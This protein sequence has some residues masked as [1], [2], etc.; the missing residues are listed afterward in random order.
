MPDFL[1]ALGEEPIVPG[2]VEASES[3]QVED[4][5]SP[6]FLKTLR[7]NHK[8]RYWLFLQWARANIR[9][10]AREQAVLSNDTTD[11]GAK[12]ESDRAEMQRALAWIHGLN[13]VEN[14]LQIHKEG[15]EGATLRPEQIPA[16]EALQKFLEN[17][18]TEGYMSLPTGFGKTVIFAELVEALDRPTLIVVPSKILVDQTVE[19]ME[20][21]APDVDVGRIYSAAKETGR[22]VTIIT[23]ASFLR[24]LADGTLNPADFDVLI[25]DEVHLSLSKARMEAISKFRGTLKIGYTATDTYSTRKDVSMLLANKIHKVTLRSAIEKKMLSSLRC[26]IVK[27]DVDLS[28]VGISADGDYDEVEMSKVLDIE[29]RNHSAVQLYQQAFSGEKAITFC[30]NIKHASNVAEA[31]NKDGVTAAVIHGGMSNEEQQELKDKFR[32][33]EITVLCNA[34]LLIVGFDDDEAS[35][36]LN[37]RPTRS[38]VMAGQRGGRVTRLDPNRPGKFAIVVDWVDKNQQR[39]QILYSHIAGGAYIVPEDTTQRGGGDRCGP[40]DIDVDIP[41]VEFIDDI[42]EVLR[43]SQGLAEDE[44]VNTPPEGWMTPA[45]LADELDINVNIIAN[46][47]RGL[48]KNVD[49]ANECNFEI[50]LFSDHRGL[51]V[52]HYS[53]ALTEELRRFF[54]YVKDIPVVPG[55][56]WVAFPTLTDRII[57]AGGRTDVDTV[58]RLIDVGYP[59]GEGFTETLCT[60]QCRYPGTIRP[61]IFVSPELVVCITNAILKEGPPGSAWLTF[62]QLAEKCGTTPRAAEAYAKVVRSGSGQIKIF[63]PAG[64]NTSEKVPHCSGSLAYRVYTYFKDLKPAPDGWLMAGEIEQDLR[65]SKSVFRD[66]ILPAM[67]TDNKLPDGDRATYMDRNKEPQEYYSPSFIARARARLATLEPPAEWM[68]VDDI[69]SANFPGVNMQGLVI[70]TA[71]KLNSADADTGDGNGQT[72][73]RWCIGVEDA[74]GLRNM[75][76]Y[77]SPAVTAITV[78]GLRKRILPEGWGTI[79]SLPGVA[80]GKRKSG[81]HSDNVCRW[82]IPQALADTGLC[83]AEHFGPRLVIEGA[84]CTEEQSCSPDLYARMKRIMEEEIEPPE[85]WKTNREIA[86]MLKRSV[87][88]VDMAVRTACELHEKPKHFRGRPPRGWRESLYFY[89]PPRLIQAVVEALNPRMAAEAR[90]DMLTWVNRDALKGELEVS[91]RIMRIL[92]ARVRSD[93]KK[94]G[95][96]ESTDGR[97]LSDGFVNEVR[98]QC[99]RFVA[100]SADWLPADEL[101]EEIGGGVNDRRV[102]AAARTIIGEADEATAGTLVMKTYLNVDG[103]ERPHLSPA[104]IEKVRARL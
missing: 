38:L 1:S 67:Y 35:V 50:K 24:R 49:S 63:V 71:S 37:L 57:K 68:N 56:D 89:Y 86:D 96:V 2:S 10:K 73:I 9:I 36:C 66:V 84:T 99:T 51:N 43:I 45:E 25:L 65:I 76:G 78:G 74:D 44:D 52:N 97:K 62:D 77:Y 12:L 33:G 41:G 19:R 23:Y 58:V 60:R 72:G 103:E 83:S 18:G 87:D 55:D 21:F 91:E 48:C 102:L 82:L 90:G 13:S 16:L 59:N 39:P 8:A 101:A 93:G 4:L 3:N 40:A 92:I 46:R 61:V 42:D 88:V 69:I 98:E 94:D 27:T 34:D 20:Q 22:Q 47:A 26:F 104:L 17:G 14:F 54:A 64:I 70:N 30:I 100:P 11:D 53:P 85:D 32:S 80:D 81:I 28:G 95:V 15:G 29:A 79:V 7:E 31:F 6:E 75:Q 5:S